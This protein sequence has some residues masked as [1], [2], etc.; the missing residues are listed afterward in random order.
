M[1]ISAS[2]R[3]DIPAYYGEWFLNRLKEGFVLIQNPY[4]TNRYSRAELSREAVDIIVFWT[5][6]PLPFLRYLPQIDAMG[7][8]Y[9]FQFTITPYAKEIERNLPHKDRLIDA[10]IDLSKKIGKERMIWRYDPIIIDSSHTIEYHTK[11]FSYMAKRLANYSNRCVISF[12]DSYKNVATRMG[13]DF[14]YAMTEENIYKTA[15][16]FSQIAGKNNLTLYSCAEEIDLEHFNIRHNACID[17]SIIENI[18]GCKIECKKDK[19]QRKACLCIEAIDI[20]TYNCCANGC[21][22]CY[23]L[24]S[25]KSSLENMQKHNPLSPVLIGKVNE[26]A[27]IT[28]RE[29]KSVVTRQLSLM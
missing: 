20:G 5:K 15:E 10:F 3:T 18:L 1:I 26:N 11:M 24:T 4:N 6:N 17:K 13:K 19:N 14:S 8:P 22:Y 2:K 16:I 9:Y 28:E 7:Y 29:K 12:V 27:I 21:N 25:E 23:A